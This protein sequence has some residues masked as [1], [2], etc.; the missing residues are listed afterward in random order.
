MTPLVD[1][2]DEVEPADVV[3]EVA[4][5]VVVVVAAAVVVV[6]VAVVA[7]PSQ[8]L[9]RTGLELHGQCS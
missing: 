6:V 4:A 9:Q 5:V 8:H 1:D 3:V 7:A 2:V